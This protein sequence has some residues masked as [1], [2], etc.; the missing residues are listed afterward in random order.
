MESVAKPVVTGRVLLAEDDPTSRAFLGAT[1]Q[2]LGLEVDTADSVASAQALAGAHVYQLWLFDAHLP[3][4]DGGDLLARLR[5]EHPDTPA[6]AHTASDQADVAE[7]LRAAGFCEVLIKPLPAAAVHAAIRRALGRGSSPRGPAPIPA[8]R[9]PL[10]DDAAAAVALNGNPAHVDA[11][12]GLFLE[13][14]PQAR[15]RVVEAAQAGDAEALRREL[16]KLRASCG[17]VGAAQLGEVLRVFQQHPR[18]AAALEVFAEVARN[19]MQ[20]AGAHGD[21]QDGSLS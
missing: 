15:Q 4:G 11:L 19:T 14:L 3:D 21:A 16:H 13:E 10:W 5:R 6:I 18:D 12:R 20:R 17:F 7:R 8:D 1:V 9:L 2:A